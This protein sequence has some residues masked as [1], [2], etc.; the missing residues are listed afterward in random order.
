M[1]KKD[2]IKIAEV[3]R[4]KYIEVGKWGANSTEAQSLSLAYIEDFMTM[5]K[6]DNPSFNREKFINYINA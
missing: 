3:L 1:N 5:L 4:S 6:E 2:Y